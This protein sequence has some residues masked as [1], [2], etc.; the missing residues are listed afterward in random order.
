MG[1]ISQNLKAVITFGGNPDNS[2]KRSRRWSAK[3][4]KDR[5][6]KAVWNDWL[7]RPEIGS[8]NQTR[9]NWPGESPGDFRKRR[10]ADVSVEI[11]KTEA[12]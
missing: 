10:Y 6:W 7:Q 5:K 8:R 11:R 4:L 12:E 2:W 9:Q 1:G 3:S